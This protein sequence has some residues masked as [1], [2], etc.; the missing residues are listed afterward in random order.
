[1]DKGVIVMNEKTDKIRKKYNRIAGIYDLLE[2]PMEIMA[3]KNWR[4]TLMGHL[5]GKVLEVGVGTGKN[6]E[7]YPEGLNITAIDFSSKM[8]KRAK[9]KAEDLNKKV[10]L[11]NMDIQKMDFHDSTFDMVY[12]TCVFCSVT[13][14]IAGLKELR[15]VCKPNG[16][17]IMIE[18]VR[19][20][21]KIL[22]TIMDLLNPVV[23]GMYGANI[24]RRTVENIRK[25]G[26]TKLEVHN[27]F[28]DIVKKITLIN[29]K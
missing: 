26:F 24:N 3:L 5:T 18:H 2:S 17:I 16:K 23:V 9:N 22:G 12:A 8:L 29:D 7:Y 14:P 28:G 13:D 10:D 11:L 25:S 1:M 19:S 20:E 15:R 27:L 6:I 21:K 4:I